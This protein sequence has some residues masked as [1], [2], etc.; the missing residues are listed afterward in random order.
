MKEAIKTCYI[1]LDLLANE[2]CYRRRRRSWKC[3]V[4]LR[5]VSCLLGAAGNN[6][7]III[8]N[9][10]IF[11]TSLGICCRV[12]CSSTRVQVYARV[13][14][15]YLH[16]QA[17][18]MTAIHA[19]LFLLHA[20]PQNDATVYLFRM[21]Q[22]GD[23]LLFFR[24]HVYK[25]HVHR[26]NNSGRM[27]TTSRATPFSWT[28]ITGD[29]FLRESCMQSSFRSANAPHSRAGSA[30]SFLSRY[31]FFNYLFPFFLVL[32]VQDY[33]RQTTFGRLLFQSG[34]YVVCSPVQH[35]DVVC[36]LSDNFPVHVARTYFTSIFFFAQTS[37]FKRL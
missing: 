29:A 10:V 31:F 2:M 22:L 25:R 34:F 37:S 21:I 7:A 12:S 33:A 20:I 32:S 3:F 1:M 4:H 24:V 23:S 35:P 17:R 19:S 14:K 30:L 5:T 13:Y 36:H 15:S 6:F 8:V 18:L 9:F 28:L 27:W 26:L 16:T 11:I